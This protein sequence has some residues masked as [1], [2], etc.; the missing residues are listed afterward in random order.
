MLTST[1]SLE[2]HKLL[3]RRELREGLHAFSPLLPCP[4][5][6]FKQRLGQPR[7]HPTPLQGCSAARD[8]K[9]SH[10]ALQ[11]V[12]NEEQCRGDMGETSSTCFAKWL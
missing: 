1:I 12:P 7:S 9:R 2:Q 5:A 4:A 3:E 11:V 6:P 10:P 8:H